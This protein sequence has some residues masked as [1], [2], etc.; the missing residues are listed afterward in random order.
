M[1]G[2]GKIALVL[3]ASCAHDAVPESAVAR[4]AGFARIEYG[5][6]AFALSKIV[7]D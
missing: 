4:I 3:L 6:G 2:V 1:D 5:E 7:A